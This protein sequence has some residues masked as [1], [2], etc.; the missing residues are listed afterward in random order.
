MQRITL[1][2][3]LIVALSAHN[4]WAQSA[5]VRQ[6]LAAYEKMRPGDEALSMYRLD[7]EDSLLGAQIRA[8][9]ENR[10]I[11]VVIIHARYGDITSGHC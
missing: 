1:L 2:L 3:P 11:C 7:W 4:A 5:E 10:P 6:V 8:M 9:R